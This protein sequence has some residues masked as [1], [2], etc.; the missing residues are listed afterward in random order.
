MAKAWLLRSLYEEWRALFC[1]RPKK[2]WSPSFSPRLAVFAKNCWWVRAARP[3]LRRLPRLVHARS[4]RACEICG[5]PLESFDPGGVRAAALPA[6]Q[7][8]DL[9]AF[10]RA[11][12]LAIY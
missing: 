1:A 2:R 3:D 10:A 5:R 7:S 4:A 9:R 12:S 11:R 6:L 8:S